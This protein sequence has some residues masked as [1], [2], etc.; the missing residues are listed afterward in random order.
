MAAAAIARGYEYLAHTDHS[1]THG[2]GNHVTPDELRRQI[3]RVRELDAQIDGIRLLIGT[4]TN[5][6]PDG[7][8]GLRRRPAGRA[9]L[10]RRLGAH[11]VPHARGGDDQADRRRVRAPVHRRDRPPDRPQDRAPQPYAVDMHQVIEA[12]ARTG[13]MLE[14]NAAPDRR[15]L[16]D[17]HA[18]HAAEAGVRILVDSDAHGV[19][20]LALV[21]WGIATAR[22]AWLPPT[23]SPTR[24]RGR[25]RGASQARR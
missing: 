10:G 18:R 13:T 16:N 24:A 9:R 23:R 2:F 5:I 19:R 14:I 20:E 12:A 11:R 21:R 4:E 15:D 17:V 3:E 22:R 6:L 1:A 8:P 25:V 7:S